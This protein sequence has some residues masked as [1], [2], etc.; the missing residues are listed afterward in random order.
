M[1]MRVA[2]VS[3]CSQMQQLAGNTT[4]SNVARTLLSH[5]PV[6]PRVTCELPRS[7]S[8]LS[9]EKFNCSAKKVIII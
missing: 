5:P 4:L 2:S 7:N 8:Q 9:W 3:S 1:A 6:T